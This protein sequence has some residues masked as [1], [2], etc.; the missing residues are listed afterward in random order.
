MKKYFF[1]AIG[2]VAF[3]IGAVDWAAGALVPHSWLFVG[4]SLVSFVAAAISHMRQRQPKRQ[5]VLPT[6]VA[7]AIAIFGVVDTCAAGIHDVLI[8]PEVTPIVQWNPNAAT[9]AVTWAIALLIGVAI[10]LAYHFGWNWLFR[11]RDSSWRSW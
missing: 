5:P 3:S 6:L 4:A 10:A 2:V 1:I 7:L 9:G 11:N 8:R